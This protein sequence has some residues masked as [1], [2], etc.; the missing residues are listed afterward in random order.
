M[1][2]EPTGALLVADDVGARVYRIATDGSVAPIIGTGT[3]G[4]SGDGG[5]ALTAEV[6]RPRALTTDPGGTIYL[7]DG[8][9]VRRVDTAG[10]IT[11]VATDAAFYSIEGL[12]VD[13][14]GRLVIAEYDRL[15]RIEAGIITTVAAGV[16]ARGMV[17]EPDGSI[18]VSE[19]HRITRIAPDGATTTIA[20]TGI[21]GFAGD[22][23][24]ATAAL[25]NT[26]R[27]LARD[28]AGNLYIA[29][30]GNWRVRRLAPD[31]TIT[32]FAGT[33]VFGAGGDDGPATDLDLTLPLLGTD[34][35]G[36]L[37]MLN[38]Q[39]A[40][41]QQLSQGVRL[42]VAELYYDPISDRPRMSHDGFGLVYTDG[43]WQHAPYAVPG[44]S[45]LASAPL[46]GGV[47]A[48]ETRSIE[49]SLTEAR[50]WRVSSPTWEVT[51]MAPGPG[52]APG[53]LLAYDWVRQAVVLVG[54]STVGRR[55]TYVNPGAAWS[56]LAG[57]AP[58]PAG[59]PSA[60]GFDPELPG[61]LLVHS[62]RVF[63]LESTA[64]AWVDLGAAASVIGGTP[65]S[66][67]YDPTSRVMFALSDAG[68]IWERRS[69]TWSLSPFAL[70]T[71][72]YRLVADDRRGL[73]MAVPLDGRDRRW[74]EYR[75]GWVE[76]GVL[77]R[78]VRGTIASD[79]R[80]GRMVILGDGTADD[81]SGHTFMLVRITR[82]GQSDESCVADE[83]ADADG[84]AGCA[85]A[86][87]FWSCDRCPLY[88][89]CP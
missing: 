85:D 52:P 29:D 55:D 68:Q 30:T 21:A 81:P 8:N 86:D 67:A 9:R 6:S 49:L 28:V 71:A 12:A 76:G 42:P 79:P 84:L 22:A 65:R 89:S 4:N 54:G 72:G 87:C 74:F 25:L 78:E 43:G 11:T 15:R 38:G 61:M 20:G 34:A 47:V 83:D 10:V 48:Y 56:S 1:A 80:H 2:I 13:P 26:P 37:Y 46:D 5:L 64:S 59:D 41:W 45:P 17:I 63:S 14:Q 32:T 58:L 33:G 69:G 66:L 18:V 73:V 50:S 40:A 53:A 19:W 75:G 36:L 44:P 24:P 16:R 51:E 88:T 77:P 62:G 27:G 57:A 23:G 70:N 3:A 31:G 35:A 39:G 82:S 60:L 7:A